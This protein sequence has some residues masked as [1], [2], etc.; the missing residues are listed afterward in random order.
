MKRIKFYCRDCGRDFYIPITSYRVY[1]KDI[2]IYCPYC[3]SNKTYKV[4]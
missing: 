2:P 4:G 1:K 3:G